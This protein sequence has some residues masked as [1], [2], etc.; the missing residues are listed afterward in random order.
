MI[1]F[2]DFTAFQV[3]DHFYKLDLDKITRARCLKTA[4]F[5]HNPETIK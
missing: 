3:V 2:A 1:T 4:K 5:N